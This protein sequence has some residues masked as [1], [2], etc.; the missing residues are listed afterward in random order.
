[1]N[2]S[3]VAQCFVSGPLITHHCTITT[4]S[5]HGQQALHHS[6]LLPTPPL[7]LSLSTPPKLHLPPSTPLLSSPFLASFVGH[8]SSLQRLQLWIHHLWCLPITHKANSFQP[9]K[10]PQFKIDSKS[11]MLTPL[12]LCLLGRYK[13]L[14]H[15]LPEQRLQAAEP[16]WKIS[17]LK[18]KYLYMKELWSLLNHSI[19]AVTSAHLVT[20]RVPVQEHC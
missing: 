14:S 11:Y 9:L 5:A 15:P 8:W 7:P 4:G 10:K 1:M 6:P 18:V 16:C 2:D 19:R 17:K 3:A 20:I 12:P 13:L